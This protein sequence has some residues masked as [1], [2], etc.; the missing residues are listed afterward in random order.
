M[1]ARIF[2]PTPEQ[3]A[4]IECWG[5][6]LAVS[7]GAGCGKT[8]TLVAKCVELGRLR[9]GA[10]FAAVSFTDRSASDLRGRLSAA[11]DLRDHWV[12]T[13]HGLCGSVVSDFPV[14]AGFDLDLSLLS[15]AE[16]TSLWGRALEA[17]W[18][19]PLSE[20]VDEA[21][22]GLLERET[23]SA[24]EKLVWRA[25]ELEPF[26]GLERLTG[27]DGANA[28]RLTRLGAYVL[29]RYRR[30]KSRRGA[31][32][33]SDLERGASL[34]LENENVRAH[35]RRRFDLVLVDEFQDTNPVQAVILSAFSRP[36]RSN[37]GVVGEPKQ[38]IYRFRDADVSLFEEFSASLP[39]RLRLTGNFRSR[40]AI[41]EFVNRACAPAFEASGSSYEALTA[42][43]EAASPGQDGVRIVEAET[44]L[45]FAAWVA[46]RWR[47]GDLV[48]DETAILLRSVKRRE[49]WVRALA[50]AGIPLA[51][52]GG[53][54]F[55]KDPRVVEAVALLGWWGNPS[56]SFSGAVCLRAPWIGVPD[57]EIDAWLRRDPRLWDA[58]RESGHP[59]SKLLD[60]CRGR[61]CRPGELLLALLEEPAIEAGMGVQ[62]LGLWH[63]CE[64]LS[65]SGMG[66]RETVRRLRRSV[67]EE[68][69]R[70][71][72]DV[73]PPRNRGRL[74]VMTIHAA[75]GL[76]FGEVI[77]LDFPARAARKEPAPPLFWDRKRGAWLPGRDEAGDRLEKDPM[78]LEWKN[79]EHHKILAES[80]RLF[81]V[82]LTRAE[83]R[84]SLVFTGLP[85]PIP[86]VEVDPYSAV[87]W[88]AWVVE[89]GGSHADATPG[90]SQLEEP[91]PFPGASV[92]T[93]PP[94][95]VDVRVTPREHEGV[96]VRVRRPRH[97]VTEWLTLSKCPRKYEWKYLRPPPELD[98]EPKRAPR[99]D[100]P[101]TMDPRELGTQVHACLETG[102]LERLCELELQ[103]GSAAFRADPLIEW[104]RRSPWM[105]G[106]SREDVWAEFA[107][108]VP[109][110]GEVL[111]GSIDR[112]VRTR[113]RAV[114]DYVVIDFK[115]TGVD[116][117]PAS[118]V[119]EYSDQLALYAWA[120][121]AL[122]PS[123]RGRV[124]ARI[125][126]ISPSAVRE[127][128]VP[129]A[130]P[131]LP[132]RLARASARIVAGEA[133]APAPGPGC[134]RCDFLASCAEGRAAKY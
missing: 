63:R 43:R 101:V 127:V 12:S 3:R 73:P 44:P 61:P 14:E 107:F 89:P 2:V 31:M 98:V 75:K 134:A 123:A 81:Y 6:G 51:V 76:E 23:R 11:L 133:G 129:P 97:S 4:V 29:Q 42:T 26:G 104:A 94:T 22:D 72:K 33:F 110:A 47:R 90:R 8:A 128:A 74:R 67:A 34:A 99:T 103:A 88:R 13:I 66:Y 117:D 24:V 5:E 113:T 126:A 119:A 35:Y 45:A 65:R 30:L 105:A 112:L 40:P 38:S 55:W 111:V 70:R 102:D 68:E 64:E 25:R 120:V 92:A 37:L 48:L 71:D 9:P 114:P 21:L 130:D 80:K 20:A 50:A 78:F 86:K 118:L 69:G 49:A 27:Q 96:R 108:E 91:G 36:Y 7:A 106:L 121:G 125:V 59:V 95:D 10:R 16:A 41:I 79:L 46:D 115:V 17:L 1:S 131:A 77:L 85:A 19:E 62:L 28:L 93:A 122:E 58:F 132:E 39:R 60:P 87:H 57:R 18:T 52:G 32:D 53:G 84:L 116:R 83:E 56:D 100:R 82:A 109:V 54:L 124:E 15:E